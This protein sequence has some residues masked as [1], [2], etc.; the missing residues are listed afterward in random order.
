MFL[1]YHRHTLNENPY[2]NIGAQDITA[3]V[4]FTSLMGWGRAE[5]FECLGYC[6]QGTFLV[7][8]GIDEFLGEFSNTEDYGFH[9]A[10]IKRLITDGGMGQ[11]HKVMIQYR[12]NGLP[13]LRGFSIKNRLSSLLL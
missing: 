10:K 5:G 3:H 1:C 4:N 12:G 7:S 13:I 8:L 9:A 6:P 2:I 11:S